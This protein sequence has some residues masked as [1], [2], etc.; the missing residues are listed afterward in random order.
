MRP[1]SLNHCLYA[2]RKSTQRNQVI[3]KKNVLTEYLPVLDIEK[4]S[5][6]LIMLYFISVFPALAITITISPNG[7]S[8]EI[9]MVGGMMV[10][11]QKGFVPMTNTVKENTDVRTNYDKSKKLNATNLSINERY[12]R[13]IP[14][15]TFYYANDLVAPTTESYST[16]VEIEKVQIVEAVLPERTSKKLGYPSY[17]NIPRYQGNRLTKY[18]IASANPGR[19]VKENGPTYQVP[20]KTPANY[21]PLILDYKYGD[22]YN[23]ARLA[24]KTSN[25]YSEQGY[26]NQSRKPH[27]NIYHIN[28]NSNI[29]YYVPNNEP[30][31]HFKLVP[32]EQTPPVKVSN[33]YENYKYPVNGPNVSPKE[34]VQ[35]RPVKPLESYDNAFVE[36]Q[37]PYRKQPVTLTENYYEKTRPSNQD[38]KF[39][40]IIESGF[41]PIIPKYQTSTESPI[42]MTNSDNAYHN[43]DKEDVETI[44]TASIAPDT[45]NNLMEP[46][47]YQYVVEQKYK[48]PDHVSNSVTLND[49]LN[50]LQ[51]S[52]SIPTPITR[53]NV[54]SSIKTL[55]QVLNSLTVAPQ[56][57]QND[58]E[59]PVLSTPKPFVITPK[60]VEVSSKPE[61]KPNNAV[62]FTEEPYLAPV[63]PPQ[64]HLDG[65]QLV[66]TFLNYLSTTCN[67]V[68]FDVKRYRIHEWEQSI[69]TIRVAI[70]RSNYAG[71]DKRFITL[72]LNDLM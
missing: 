49:L 1:R 4:T 10:D 39:Q 43:N 16:N 18:N 6:F 19:L 14:Y 20:A 69:A 44:E 58:V 47:Y 32:Y 30:T 34:Y 23:N 31:Q 61:I 55:L 26:L 50:A 54:G 62:E 29:R 37:L 3:E 21:N 70:Y 45:S 67:Q 63:N 17:H 28:N 51:K 38:F 27:V 48:Q 13:L 52:N 5:V 56:H 25:R 65:M 68:P 12:R 11:V 59:A 42:Y 46:N 33:V 60:V 40:P 36:H 35:H 72:R 9:K 24:H 41:K 15:M 53:N 57:Y 7:N 66:T 64:Q 2:V 71:L 8:P 22:G